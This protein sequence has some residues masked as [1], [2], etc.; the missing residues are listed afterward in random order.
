MFKNIKKLVKI[1]SVLEICLIMLAVL[2]IL[3]MF[4][5]PTKLIEQ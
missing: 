5:L 1:R 3:D 4:N 2:C